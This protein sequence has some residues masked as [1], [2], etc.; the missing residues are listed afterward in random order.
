MSVAPDFKQTSEVNKF[1]FSLAVQMSATWLRNHNK[2]PSD[3]FDGDLIHSIDEKFVA[4][5]N[6]CQFEGRF[7]RI[8]RDNLTYFLDGAH[9]KESMDIC[10][11]WFAQQIK[12][13][14]DSINVL[15][16]NVTGDRDSA[17]ILRCMHSM[18]FHYVCF[19]TNIS[20]S[21]S[22]NGK[23]GELSE[24]KSRKPLVIMLVL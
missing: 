2:I 19:A 1:N 23:N 22:D 21:K 16:F 8:A 10:S 11:S 15:V 7:Q 9:T 24:L 20:T 4:A 5:F 13:S 17:A 3:V 18:N 12:N 14:K 6:K